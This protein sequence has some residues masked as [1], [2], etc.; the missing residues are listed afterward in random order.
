[1]VQGAFQTYYQSTLLPSSTSSTIAFVGSLQVF[2]LC[3]LGVFLGKVFDAYGS[4]VSFLFTSNPDGPM[5]EVLQFLIY[6]GSVLSVFSLMMLSL[7]QTDQAYQVFL[8]HGVLFGIGI[9]M[10]YVHFVLVH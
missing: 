4:T 3:F 7:V 9:S 5:I 8:S 10:L 1:M 6:V 2:L